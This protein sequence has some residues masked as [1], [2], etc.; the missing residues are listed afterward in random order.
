LAAL[1]LTKTGTNDPEVAQYLR[2]VH[3]MILRIAQRIQDRL[4]HNQHFDDMV[5][6]GLKTAWLHRDHHLRL[7]RPEEFTRWLT[8]RAKGAML[9]LLR[10]GD[11]LPRRLRAKS[12]QL[13]TASAACRSRL[14][15][16][17]TDQELAEEAGMTVDAVHRHF[18]D[19]GCA[20]P[21]YLD[22]YIQSGGQVPVEQCFSDAGAVRSELLEILSEAIAQLPTN[23]KTALS[24]YILEELTLEEVGQVMGLSGKS[25]ALR[26]VNA[27]IFS[28]RTHLAARNLSADSF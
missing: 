13:E 3:P 10:E 24:L 21:D 14:M 16:L 25:S 6:A 7:S 2:E 18:M 12:R 11:P 5:Q 15:R 23:E 22:D 19:V 26:L 4:P 20:A 28:C 1:P 17:P 8:I 27:A 9:D